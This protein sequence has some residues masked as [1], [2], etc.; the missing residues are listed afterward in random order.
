M[1]RTIV[2]GLLAV[3]AA[4]HDEIHELSFAETVQLV[5]RASREGLRPLKTFRIEMH[6][7]R[8]YWYNVTNVL[9][10]AS[11]CRIFEHPQLVYRCEWNRGKITL[12]ALAAQIGTALGDRWKRV[13]PSAT[14]VRFEPLNARREGLVELRQLK[15]GVDAT[16]HRVISI[17]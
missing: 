6:P 3:A 11:M 1:W 13:D 16:F 5:V 2:A 8:D 17:E 4:G 7:S 10:G 12:A 9:P 15:A 14:V